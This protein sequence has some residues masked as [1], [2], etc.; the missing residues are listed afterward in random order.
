MG[1]PSIKLPIQV[2]IWTRPAQL[3]NIHPSFDQA[4]TKLIKIICDKQSITDQTKIWHLITRLSDEKGLERADIIFD[5]G[6]TA[7]APPVIAYDV[8]FN[9]P[10][11]VVEQL[12]NPNIRRI[13][14]RAVEAYRS[15]NLEI[16]RIF[17]S[18]PDIRAATRRKR[19]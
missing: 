6:L 10:D 1:L 15:I 7:V 12:S 3:Q 16:G 2:L 19:L 11:L 17:P 8:T 5:Y 9:G 18:Q 13:V 14:N 4:D